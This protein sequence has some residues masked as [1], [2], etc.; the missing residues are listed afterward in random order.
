VGPADARHLWFDR[1]LVDRL[2]AIARVALHVPLAPAWVTFAILLRL[3]VRPIRGAPLPTDLSAFFAERFYPDLVIYVLIACVSMVRAYTARMND[4]AME[5]QERA[6]DLERKLAEAALQTLRAQLQPH[7]LFNALNTIS[8]FT[9]TDPRTARRLMAQLGQLLRASLRHTSDALVTL[10]DELTFLDDYL[11]IESARF[12]GRL[13]VSVT[14]D[15]ELMDVRVPTFLLQPLVENAIRHGVAPRLAAGSVEV[16]VAREGG[17]L[18]VRVRDNGVGLPEGW[19]FERDQGVGLRNLAARLAYL[20][21][22]GGTLR[23]APR[24]IGGVDVDVTIP[25]A[26]ATSASQVPPSEAAVHV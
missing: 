3:I 12:E 15:D 5:A 8:A 25:L 18:H 20:Y 21:G 6:A 14:A 10:G 9:E 7:F 19:D 4:R 11:A 23:V 24:Q 17:H 16:T 1:R 13:T 26:Q 2:P 22:A